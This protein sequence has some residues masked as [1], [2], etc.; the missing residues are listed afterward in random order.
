MKILDI[1]IKK[2]TK[3]ESQYNNL[4][5]LVLVQNNIAR[6][7][8]LTISTPDPE[9]TENLKLFLL[10]NRHKLKNWINNQK[11]TRSL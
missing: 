2:V 6:R 5:S 9:P 1:K 3:K 4:C 10:L 8:Y 11:K 7:E